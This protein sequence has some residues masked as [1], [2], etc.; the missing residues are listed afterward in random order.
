MAASRSNYTGGKSRYIVS[1]DD[2]YDDLENPLDKPSQSSS[3]AP[4][5]FTRLFFGA[6]ASSP[7]AQVV[8]DSS[9][10]YDGTQVLPSEDSLHSDLWKPFSP[11][12]SSLNPD[13]TVEKSE[14]GLFTKLFK[15]DG[16]GIGSEDT[17]QTPLHSSTAPLPQPPSPQE[18]DPFCNRSGDSFE[19][20]LS[21][22][23][24]PSSSAQSSNSLQ[25]PGLTAILSTVSSGQGPSPFSVTST[26]QNFN[27]GVRPDTREPTAPSSPSGGNSQATKLFSSRDTA[28]ETSPFPAGPSEFT[29]IVNSPVRRPAQEE[30]SPASGNNNHGL[31]APAVAPQM[32]SWPVA[33][34]APVAFP[35]APSLPGQFSPPVANPWPL[36]MPATPPAPVVAPPA[37]PQISPE[38]PQPSGS[39]WTTYFPLILFFN[40]LFFL[41]VVLILIFAF[42]K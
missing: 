8:P 18:R 20:P 11:Q 24:I 33:A 10:V 28:G 38:L 13:S 9:Q 19:F 40:L 30:A 42:R 41:I 5:Q 37:P 36:A 32:P 4:G 31:N 2:K 27:Y 3:A 1:A 21:S 26:G 29:K 23:T 6:G 14:P 34:P 25:P 17:P 22:G 16:L 35:P 39:V 12:P 15:P 7:A